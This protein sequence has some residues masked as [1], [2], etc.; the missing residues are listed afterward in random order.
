MLDA[1]MVATASCII[2]CHCAS[3]ITTLQVA[4]LNVHIV[5]VAAQSII[6]DEPGKKC[7]TVCLQLLQEESCI[8]SIKV[9]LS[10]YF[11]ESFKIFFTWHH[12]DG[13]LL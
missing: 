2:I 1:F 11:T 9:T 12:T 4:R 3:F 8:K 13:R 10:N 6:V 5:Q 7:D